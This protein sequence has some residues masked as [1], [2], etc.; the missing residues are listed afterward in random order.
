MR[1]LLVANQIDQH[2]GEAIDR[3]GWLPVGGCEI[4]NRERVE[5]AVGQRMAVNEQQ[6]AACARF[7]HVR[8]SS[9]AVPDM[10]ELNCGY[11]SRNRL[12]RSYP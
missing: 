4:I 2:R 1:W 10:S 11:V 6:L 9:W 3:I 12:S 8:D 5:G 7:T